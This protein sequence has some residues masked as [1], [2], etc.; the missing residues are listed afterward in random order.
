M[1]LQQVMEW[2]VVDPGTGLENNIY[3]DRGARVPRQVGLRRGTSPTFAGLLDV[4]DLQELFMPDE[5]FLPD[6]EDEV[7]GDD[8]GYTGITSGYHAYPQAGLQR[9]GHFQANGMMNPVKPFIKEINEQL[10]VR[11]RSDSG[12]REDEDDAPEMSPHPPVTGVATQGYNSAMHYARGRGVQHHDAQLG[13]VTAAIGGTYAVSAKEKRIALA[14]QQSCR[15][16]LPHE[17]FNNKIHEA[18]ITRDLRM[19]NVY[20]V[21]MLAIKPE[22]R[23]GG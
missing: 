10:R 15:H 12:N 8:H 1:T 11:N 7:D 4:K 13:L 18:E 21:D 19:E 14:R 2:P 23:S 3:N 17:R 6:D 9:Y 16:N 5:L 22:Y 20:C